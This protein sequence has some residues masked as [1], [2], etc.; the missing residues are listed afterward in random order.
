MPAFTDAKWIWTNEVV[1][2]SYVDFRSEFSALDFDGY[3]IRI[4]CD[5]DYT[6]FVNGKF[7]DCNQYGD[8]EHYK[9][10]DE[11]CLD[12]FIAKQNVIEILAYH[13]GV[14][15]SRHK[16]NSAGI[17]FEVFKNGKT[18][19]CSS[20]TTLSRLNPAYKHGMKKFIT[21]QLGFTYYYDA[22]KESDEGFKPACIVNKTCSLSPRPNEKLKFS[23]PVLPKS[24][25]KVTPTRY[26][27]DL[28]KE[29]VGVP[30][31]RFNSMTKQ[32]VIFTWGEHLNDG[33]V[34]RIIGDRD[35]S[36]TYV[37]KEGKNDFSNYMLRLGCRYLEVYFEYEV[38]VQQLTLLEQYYPI[39][40]VPARLNDELDQKIYNACV[41]TLKNCM[42]EHYVDCPWREQAFY[43]FDSRN[44]ILCGYYA[45]ENGNAPYVRSNLELIC[46]DKREDGLLSIC[47]PCSTELAIPSF[48]LHF[49]TAMLEYAQYTN[50]FTLAKKYNSRLKK[51]LD[52]FLAREKNGLIQ[53]FE[54][55][56]YWNFYD[57]T[58]Y[59][60]G[61]LYDS[62]DVH[63]DCI[64]NL[65]TII[66]LNN[67]EKLCALINEPFPYKGKSQYLKANVRNNFLTKDGLFS[68]RK[69]TD[70][71]CAFA[72]ALA[73]CS[74]VTTDEETKT[75]AKAITENKLIKS[76]LST[77]F[78]VYEAILKADE[79]YKTYVLDD[80]RTT[81]KKMLDTGSDTVWET[82]IGA[83][84]F[85]NAGSLCHG[86]SAI[87]IYFYHKF[88][89]VK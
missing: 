23:E 17:I 36:F 1:Q 5:T 20:N 60:E 56:Q 62:K 24:I 31:L 6:L 8:Y 67:Y 86:W 50:D 88:N 19:C 77:K 84:D 46:N 52:V 41:N 53:A 9:I 22:N 34:R 58:R 33:E 89:L 30:I 27:I 12:G 43:A 47:Y 44:Q 29:T 80:I 35:F 26:R 54:G 64:L 71:L 69:N 11:I 49:F 37:A 15:N 25:I 28:G 79:N 7:V 68:M 59:C 61:S 10:Y 48:S 75:I 38:D 87:P 74:G 14:G 65:L 13:D 18:V 66:A 2:D 70:E 45:F 51:I 83:S 76:T 57:W 63:T 42:M 78:F 85:G 39:T 32:T 81:Y 82:E 21:Y 16:A 4:S 40:V 73:V 72:C 3:S 55:K